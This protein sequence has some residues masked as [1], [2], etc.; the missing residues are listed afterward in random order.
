[1]IFISEGTSLKVHIMDGKTN[2]KRQ[3]SSSNQSLHGSPVTFNC[4]V[5]CLLG[6]QSC[7]RQRFC[8][9]FDESPIKVPQC[10]W[11]FVGQI[12][13]SVVVSNI[14]YFHSYLGRWSNLTNIFQMG[15]NHQLVFD[16]FLLGKKFRCGEQQGS[17]G[18]WNYIHIASMPWN[19]R[20]FVA[21]C[22]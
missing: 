19:E 2:P 18:W 9:V 16:S 5:V 10:T 12:M 21:N 7:N 22:L 17:E 15:W 3:G 11:M 6:I 4:R 20:F 13:F 14:C 8:Q 1:M